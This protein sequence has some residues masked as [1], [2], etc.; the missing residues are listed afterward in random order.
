MFQDM[1]WAK[2]SLDEIAGFTVDTITEKTSQA[3]STVTAAAEKAKG[4]MNET[5]HSAA[6]SIAETVQ[7]SK[8]SLTETTTQAI[9]SIT[10][11]T[12]SAVSTVT[13][14][15]Q[16]ASASLEETARV[17][18]NLNKAAASAIHDAVSAAIQNWL[19]SHP[20]ISWM[21]SHPVLDV[22]LFLLALFMLSGLFKALGSL[23]EKIWLFLLRSPLKLG[24]VFL[25]VAVKKR[26][27]TKLPKYYHS[28][29]LDNSNERITKILTR[30]EEIRQE[31]NHLLQEVSA[32][33]KSEKLI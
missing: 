1:N 24:H 26:T 16:Q 5:A 10:D 7:Q 31:Q 18:D 32:M 2:D 30:L 20:V 15:A 21:I 23:S 14:T 33:L 8:N 9:H 27:P 11:A 29:S 4:T 13:E 19:D 6:N 25:N 28:A 17:A 3:V 12:K 22:V